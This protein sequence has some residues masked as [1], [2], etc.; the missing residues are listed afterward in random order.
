M[1]GTIPE[2]FARRKADVM[3]RATP[4]KVVIINGRVE[5]LELFE[6]VL[7]GT[8]FDVVLLDSTARA[9]SQIKRMQPDLVV[10]CLDMDETEGFKVLSML[11][12]DDA[13][14][15]IPVLTYM[16]E[17]EGQQT[18]ADASLEP[19]DVGIRDAIPAAWMN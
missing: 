14:R 18:E 12:L 10:M 11:Q 7:E 2:P 16:I 15:A 13:T 19:L 5:L 17:F 9:Y 6:A 3:L 4:Y 8:R 1:T